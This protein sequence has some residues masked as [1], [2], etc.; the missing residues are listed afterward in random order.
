MSTGKV[1][2]VAVLQP[3]SDAG[4]QLT[5]GSGS[6]ALLTEG[7]TSSHTAAGSAPTASTPNAKGSSRSKSTAS[8]SIEFL[9]PGWRLTLLAQRTPEQMLQVHL[10]MHAWDAAQALAHVYRMDA[11]AVYRARWGSRRVDESAI[12]DCLSVMGDRWVLTQISQ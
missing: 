6:G 9:L 5:R 4:T 3:L 11:D 2:G 8:G 7:S 10:R 1:R 12:Q